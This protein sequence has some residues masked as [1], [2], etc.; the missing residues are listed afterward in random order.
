MRLNFQTID[1]ANVNVLIRKRSDNLNI[2]SL[3]VKML[4]QYTNDAVINE[5]I[6]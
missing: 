4:F 6:L 2:E 3:D 5:Q 1:S